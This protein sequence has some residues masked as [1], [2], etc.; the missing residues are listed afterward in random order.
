MEGVIV[1]GKGVYNTFFYILKV[2][3]GLNVTE[4]YS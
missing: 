1:S 4:I 2:V 3:N